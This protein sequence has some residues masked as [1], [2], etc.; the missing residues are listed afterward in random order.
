M[1]ETAKSFAS[2]SWA[3]SVFSAQQF[4]NLLTD[5]TRA[6]AA[7]YTVTE[8]AIRQFSTEPILFGVYQI[9]DQIQRSGIDLAGDALRLRPLD[10]Q[11]VK[12]TAGE[13]ARWLTG[14]A[15]AL[16]PGANLDSTVKLLRNTFDVINLVNRSSSMLDLPPGPIHL[17]SALARAYSFGDYSPLWLIEGL[18]EAYADQSWSAGPPRALL[19]T[20]QGADLPVQALLMM[21]AGMGIS[22]AK[23]FVPPLTPVSPK[24]EVSAAL[25]SFVDLVRANARPGYEGP[26]F[27][28]L[29]LVTQT[30]YSLMIPLIDETLAGI[31]AA[32]VEFFWHGV[33][34]SLYFSPMY[35]IPGSS[36]FRAAS[37]EAPH[38]LGRL[39]ATAG[40]AWAFT[41]VNIKQPEVLLNLIRTAG[42]SLQANDA[43]TDGVVSTLM[44]A[45][46]MIPGDPYPRALCA[47]RPSCGCEGLSARWEQM[48]RR[49]CETGLRDYFPVLQ[50]SGKLGEI[51]RYQNWASF[52]HRPEVRN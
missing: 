46:E 32:A 10:P 18:G 16:T 41:L 27:E 20:G 34:R 2:L 11:W 42:E 26:A 19:T 12:Q 31:D 48:V 9:G 38:Q 39:N 25:R 50:R 36:P 30:W 14:A 4:V 6:E 17:P 3:A 51:F 29:G 24:A 1:V 15:Q 40:A 21:H 8:A 7:Y 23:R 52:A 43:F 45:T 5:R 35:L 33:G 47:Y 37:S 28:S 44:M 22:F 49:P 13:A